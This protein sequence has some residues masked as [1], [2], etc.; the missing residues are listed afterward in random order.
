MKKP[1][2]WLAIGPLLLAGLL[3]VLVFFSPFSITP[4]YSKAQLNQFAVNPGS[5]ANFVGYSIKNQAF[6]NP[7][8]LPILGSS[9][10]EKFD[11][12]HPSVFSEKYKTS[13][14]PFLVG[15]PGTQSLPLFFYTNS[16][17][18]QLKDRKMVVIISPQWFTPRGIPADALSAFVSKGEVY[19]WL[20]NADPKQETTRLLAG[21]LLQFPDFNNDLI[22]KDSLK[23]LK[24]GKAISTV[25]KLAI[26]IADRFWHK[27]DITFSYFNTLLNE[28]SN[29]ESMIKSLAKSLPNKL[30]Y[31][32][33]DD[34]AYQ[35]GQKMADNNPYNIKN[36]VWSKNL[37]PNLAHY[38]DSQQKT[39]YLASPEYADFQ[40]LLNEFAQNKNDVEFIIQPVNGAWI[41][42][43]G[44]SSDMMQKFAEKIRYQLESQGF[45]HI[46][47]LTPVQDQPYYLG[48]TIHLG[49]RGW[50]DVDGAISTFMKDK[51]KPDYHI[52]NDIFLSKDWQTNN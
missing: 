31:D 16:V 41:N 51:S 23:S 38:K 49:Y 21:R 10:L 12:F 6:A 37:K 8:Y 14:T 19:T 17:A 34:A 40:F 25:N 44:L 28:Q 11:P 46:T 4:K 3:A 47:D 39:S 13:Y 26:Q 20:N 43:T 27:E 42:Y 30:N 36:S 33:L 52:Q 48:D 7:N 50:A 29:Q 15:Q 5:M 22:I 9:E 2:F 45:N 35:A 1:K 24:K 18:N 32:D